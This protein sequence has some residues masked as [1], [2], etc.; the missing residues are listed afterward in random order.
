MS[1]MKK[2]RM[3]ELLAD[4][5]VY[6]AGMS[7]VE[8]FETLSKDFPELAGDDSFELAAS[9]FA[10]SEIQVE[11]SMPHNLKASILQDAD[12]YFGEMRAAEPESSAPVE[13]EKSESSGPMW[14]WLGW[15]VAAAA[16]IA[17]VANVYFTRLPAVD[18]AQQPTVP[19]KAEPTNSEKLQNLL[20]SA[21]TIKVAWSAS[22]AKVENLS[23]EVV[24]ND[25]KQEGYMVFKNLPVND[26][27]KEQYQLWIFEDGKLEDH[28]KDGGV[29]DI[30]D[31]GEAVVPI[32][33]KL[34]VKEPKAFAVTVEKPGGVVV[35]KREKIVAL[36]ALSS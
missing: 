28:P 35:S 33:A 2:E 8:E 3:L 11:D 31:T 24:W 12:A 17:L 19:T 10:V 36:G 5:A 26:A 16:C 25:A 1:D 9:A 27:S 22:P 14:N 29:F 32:D 20:A 23:G 30:S 13:A 7:N 6:G 15:A 21:D 18:V 34:A 4:R